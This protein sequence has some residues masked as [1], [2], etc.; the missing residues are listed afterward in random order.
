MQDIPAEKTCRKNMQKK[1]AGPSGSHAGSADS[2][3]RRHESVDA[4][5]VGSSWGEERDGDSVG[6]ATHQQCA[7]PSPDGADAQAAGYPVLYQTKDNACFAVGRSRPARN[8]VSLV[9]GGANENR[10]RG[11]KHK[12]DRK[13]A[14]KR[15]FEKNREKIKQRCKKYCEKNREK[16]NQYW[17]KYREENR[18]WFNQ[19]KKRYRQKNRERLNQYA[20]RYRQKNPE[21][22]KKISERYREK[23][24]DEIRQKTQRWRQENPE[25]AKQVAQRQKE[26]QREEKNRKRCNQSY[27]EKNKEQ[28]QT[29]DMFFKIQHATDRATSAGETRG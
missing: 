29:L 7:Q 4:T 20:K 22:H 6:G 28:L 8:I 17:Q 27:Y 18:E 24:R 21:I 26:K 1:H 13:K 15:Y 16:I 9:G 2:A 3:E 5:N 11:E 14:A 10:D 23:H 12:Q 19:Y 25:K